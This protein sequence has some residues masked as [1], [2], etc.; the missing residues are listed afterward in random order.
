ML[1]PGTPGASSSI[2]NQPFVQ[3][4]FPA[5]EMYCNIHLKLI[6][7]PP[8]TKY[9]IPL[10]HFTLTV[11]PLDYLVLLHLY[12][13]NQHLRLPQIKFPANEIHALY[14]HLKLFPPPSTTQ[15]SENKQINNK[16]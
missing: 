9:D 8:Q 6:P 7:P 2:F 4:N 1:V 13:L 16:K 10:K 12:I 14:I 3:T 5:I 15:P 11:K